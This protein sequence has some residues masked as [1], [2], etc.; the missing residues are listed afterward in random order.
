MEKIDNIL[1]LSYKIL[2]I[3]YRKKRFIN[4]KTIKQE[5]NKELNELKSMNCDKKINISIDVIELKFNSCVKFLLKY[6][7]IEYEIELGD[8]CFKINNIGSYLIS[9]IEE[10]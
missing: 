8:R 5:L 9:K 7:L 4:E 10:E 2:S 6:S 1:K 3:L